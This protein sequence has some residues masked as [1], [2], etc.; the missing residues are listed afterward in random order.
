M[1][2]MTGKSIHK[3][4]IPALFKSGIM[5]LWCS[6]Y[7]ICLT[8]RRSAVLGQKQFSIEAAMVQ[9]ADK[10]IHKESIPAHF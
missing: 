10:I 8:C 1:V 9:M 2:Q 4:L 3:E 5:S 6:G 7:Y